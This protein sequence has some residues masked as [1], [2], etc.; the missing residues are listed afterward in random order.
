[1]NEKEIDEIKKLFRSANDN[2]F[3]VSIIPAK[4]TILPPGMELL[5]IIENG[6]ETQQIKL[7]RGGIER[8]IYHLERFLEQQIFPE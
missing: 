6:Y 3:N 4:F 5:I 8:L 7:T 1:M 2:N